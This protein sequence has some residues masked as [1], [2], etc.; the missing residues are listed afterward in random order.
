MSMMVNFNNLM[1]T[2]QTN[3][4]GA[5][6]ASDGNAPATGFAALFAA[7]QSPTAELD[8]APSAAQLQQLAANLQNSENPQL[9]EEIGLE[10][11]LTPEALAQILS[12]LQQLQPQAPSAQVMP[13]ATA[14]NGVAPNAIQSTQSVVQAMPQV[15]Q[16][17]S[18][19]AK[20]STQQLNQ[21]I[22]KADNVKSANVIASTLSTPA[23]V[24]EPQQ[25]NQQQIKPETAQQLSAELK[26]VDTKATIDT[27]RLAPTSA[28]PTPT[29]G[30]TLTSSAM[31]ASIVMIDAPVTQGAQAPVATPSTTAATATMATPVG[32]QAWA[33]Q[34]QQNVMQMVMHN[35]NEMTLRLHPAELGPL[36]VQLRM[37]DSTAQLNILTHSQHVRGAL[38]QAMPTLR[39]ALANQGIQLG[40]SQV[41]D[42]SQQFMQQHAR[43]Q[44]QQWTAN[45]Q[46]NEQNTNKSTVE[47]S[48]S[49]ENTDMGVNSRHTAAAHN[50]QVD[51]FA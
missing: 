21:A 48:E 5:P 18:A 27:S 26:Q 24:N 15:N 19:V 22:L 38:E 47:N 4:K 32:S 51:T 45:A 16:Q 41:S 11:D 44:A 36:Q 12:Q 2:T 28:T 43:Q 1:T 6:A 49:A 29:A 33:N 8:Q 25:F 13:E 20:Q 46:Q 3:A 37:D 23:G 35:Q 9:L 50:G 14:I 39:D 31:S 30:S 42:Q 10:Q 40:D 7:L 34:L 17:Q